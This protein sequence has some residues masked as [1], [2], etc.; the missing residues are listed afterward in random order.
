MI[1]KLLDSPV[2]D[3][4]KENIQVADLFEK[5]SIDYCCGGSKLLKDALDEKK[6]DHNAFL[7]ELKNY[8]NKKTQQSDNYNDLEL[9]TLCEVIVNKHHN[10]I[11][12]SVPEIESL[13]LKVINAHGGKYPFLEIINNL[14]AELS[15]ELMSHLL[16]EERVLF[17][18]IRYLVNTK[19][20]GEKPKT[21]GYGTIKNPISQMIRE[22]DNAGNII[23]NIATTTSGY[24]L[25]KDAC[26]TFSLL[27]EKLKEFEKDLHIH[28]HLENNILF[29]RAIELENSIINKE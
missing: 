11:R 4:V 2:G 17:P 23:E 22:H 14:F 3:I 20:A 8:V 16:K 1:N 27:Y 28:V 26:V 15:K 25:P 6:I 10:Y 18:L 24:N 29:T 21:K 9:D 7:H 12:S 19:K 5:Y 13:L